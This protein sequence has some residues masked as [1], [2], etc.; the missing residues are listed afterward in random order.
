MRARLELVAKVCDAVQHAHDK[1]VVHRDLKPGNILVE[2]SGQPKVLDFGIAHVTVAGLL[3]TGSQTQ[4]GLLLGTWSYMSP[5]QL[6]AHPS[7]LDGRSDVYALGVLLYE[8]LAE[9]MPYQLDELPM[10]EVS[11]VIEH[12][13]PL[14]L[15]S[16]ARVYRGDVEVI[17]AKALEKDK[18]RRYA[19]A[20]GLASDIRRHLRGEAILARKVSTTERYWRL[21]RRNP[22]IATLGGVLTA[23]LIATTVGSM[24]AATYFRSL[25]GREALTNQKSQEAQKEAEAAK[26]LA[27]RQAEANR[28]SLYFAQMNLAGQARALP[29]GLAA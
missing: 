8:L 10:H 23:V 13:E 21:A 7:G 18:T 29:G 6:K 14:R 9:R 17:A 25:A 3:T 19:S 27:Q 4:T 12:E 15:G 28:R 16:I 2:E 22:W 11:R 1:G 26:A 20:G 5:E 24:V